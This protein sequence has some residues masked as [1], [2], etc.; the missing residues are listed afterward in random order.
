MDDR[1]WKYFKVLIRVAK[2]SDTDVFLSA[3]ELLE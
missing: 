3:E 1:P 2:N